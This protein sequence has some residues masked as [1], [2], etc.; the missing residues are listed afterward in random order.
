MKE[1]LFQ[2]KSLGI[3]FMTVIYLVAFVISYFLS[4]WIKDELLKLFFIDIVSTI[5]IWIISLM[6][7][8]SSLYDPYWSVTPL[9]FVIYT[10]I[11][12]RDMLNIYHF[13]FIAVFAIWAIR[14]TINWAITFTNLKTEDWRYVRFRSL[15][16]IKWHFANF[17]GIMIIPTLVVFIGYIPIYF[18]LSMEGALLSLIGSAIVFL[19]I[20]LEFFADHQIHTFTKSSK[21]KIT[22]QKGLWKYSRHPNYLGEIMIWIGSYLVLICTNIQYW[23]YFYGAL[24][25][26]CLF[27]FISIPL[28]EKR[29]LA[30][31][32]DYLEYKQKTSRL[33]LLPKK[34]K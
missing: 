30:R 3:I 18:F 15:S 1:K 7:H 4:Y 33:I 13:I 8:N 10:S 27:N 20:V 31:R 6:I 29:Q 19:G 11:V 17:F 28:M 25:M 21:E 2:K 34:N 32:K 12:N 26:I 23:H 24:G 5:F 9:V 22:C 16:G 14:L